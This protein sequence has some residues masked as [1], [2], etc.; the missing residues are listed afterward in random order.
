LC[1]CSTSPNV[2]GREFR[3]H[4]ASLLFVFGRMSFL[5]QEPALV[6]RAGGRVMNRP[7]MARSSVTLP[8]RI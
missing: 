6:I 3:V 2:T 8:D 4:F 5:P 1:C 7:C